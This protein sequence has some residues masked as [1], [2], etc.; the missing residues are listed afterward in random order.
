M[1]VPEDVASKGL[2]NGQLEAPNQRYLVCFPSYRIPSHSGYITIRKMN[3]I[4]TQDFP[5]TG[6][7]GVYE[8]V[9]PLRKF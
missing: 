6:L 3:S 4:P 7:P 9:N 5:E 2:T 1:G 8:M